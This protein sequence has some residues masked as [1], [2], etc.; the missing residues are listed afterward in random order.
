MSTELERYAHYHVVGIPTDN[1]PET[2]TATFTGM[3]VAKR[4]EVHDSSSSTSISANS[5]VGDARVVV[6]FGLSNTFDVSLTNFRGSIPELATGLS[7]R[8]TGFHSF[9]DSD[10]AGGW[11]I[12]GHLYGPNAEEV[13]GSFGYYT[14]DLIDGVRII[15]AYGTTRE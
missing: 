1:P 6:N 9:S 7:R 11:N 3:A 4:I 15:G 10:G 2:G 12:F 8:V 14:S 13:A 5:A